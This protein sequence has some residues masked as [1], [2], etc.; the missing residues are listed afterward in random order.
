MK[1]N[2]TNYTNCTCDDYQ[3]INH[4]RLWDRLSP[5]PH[6]SLSFSTKTRICKKLY[7]FLGAMQVQK[8]NSEVFMQPLHCPINTKRANNLMRRYQHDLLRETLS[9]TRGQWHYFSSKIKSLTLKLKRRLIP[10]HFNL[11]TNL[12]SASYEK[13]FEKEKKS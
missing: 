9:Q 8:T 4:N 7:D 2:S 1:T 13:A 3:I 10:D 6:L 5:N 11:V 12:V